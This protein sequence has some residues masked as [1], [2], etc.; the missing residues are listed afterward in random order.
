MSAPSK[1]PPPSSPTPKNLGGLLPY[2][3]KY[4][5]GLTVGMLTLTIGAVGG[6]FIPLVIRIITD[7]LAG[8]P[9]PLANLPG[10]RGIIQ[11]L[12]APYRPS[13]EQ[14]LLAVPHA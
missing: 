12:S 11:A 5:R 7:C 14:T 13:D 2:L 8:T 9:Q 1:N 10:G 4:K 6:N 3:A